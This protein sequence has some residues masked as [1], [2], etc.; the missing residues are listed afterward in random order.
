MMSFHIE[1]KKKDKD[2]IKFIPQTPL[3]YDSSQ[4]SHQDISVHKTSKRTQMALKS[5]A[6][7]HF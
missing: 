3:L 5:I 2:K 1:N 4:P 7:P 6:F